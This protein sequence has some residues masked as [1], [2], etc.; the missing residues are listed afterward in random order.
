MRGARS[1]GRRGRGG[2]SMIE[3][4][5]SLSVFSMV[6]VGLHRLALSSERSQEIGSRITHVNQDLR[7][8]LEIISRDLRM[9]GSG[10]AGIPV[11]TAN[12]SAREVIFPITPGYTFSD[13]TDSVSVLA[14]FGDATTV[15]AEEMA[16]PSSDIDCLSLD[17][18]AAGDLLVITDG[19]FADMFEITGLV[20]QGGGSGGKLLHDLSR[21]KNDPGGH[22]QWPAGGYPAG[23]RAA[24][25][26]RITLQAVDEQGALRLFR[27]VDGGTPIP[28]I[29]DLRTITFTYRLPDGTETRNP[30][31]PRDIQE[32]I[33]NIEAG[34]RSG[35]GLEDRS[36]VTSTSVRPRSV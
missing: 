26:N 34:L 35:W 1:A 4:L 14:G 24:K 25:V 16:A 17:G 32:V 10:F 28:I 30:P 15:L 6:L 5:I 29:N 19:V 27:R 2:F 31:S 23:S 13:D 33:F 20:P 12:G 36:V 3:M 18:F 21:P 9:A 8:A 7:A 22:S 11:Q